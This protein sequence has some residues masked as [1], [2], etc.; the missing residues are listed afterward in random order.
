MKSDAKKSKIFSIIGAPFIIFVLC[1]GML[2]SSLSSP[3]SLSLTSNTLTCF[4]LFT[5]MA[6]CCLRY[7]EEWSRLCR[8]IAAT[9]GWYRQHTGH[10]RFWSSLWT[11]GQL[12]SYGTFIVGRILSSCNRWYKSTKRPSPSLNLAIEIPRKQS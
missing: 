9:D 6:F 11:D 10:V 2:S 12:W 3:L 8:F 5:I 7:F 4:S 1:W